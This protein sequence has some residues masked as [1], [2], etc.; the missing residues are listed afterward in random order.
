MVDGARRRNKQRVRNIEPDEDA[1]RALN[2]K[3]V[4]ND[5]QSVFLYQSPSGRV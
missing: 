5:N 1:I 3:S 4:F 2:N